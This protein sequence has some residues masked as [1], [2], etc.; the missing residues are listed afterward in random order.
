[1]LVV[2]SS[3]ISLGSLEF[4][5]GGAHGYK[6]CMRLLEGQP[7]VEGYLS[8]LVDHVKLIMF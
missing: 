2:V 5:K 4:H 8:P 3:L 7:A 1:M 6:Y